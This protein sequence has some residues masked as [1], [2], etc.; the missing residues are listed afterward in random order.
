MRRIRIQK[1]KPRSRHEVEILPLDARDP[2]VVRAKALMRAREAVQDVRACSHSCHTRT[3]STPLA[4]ERRDGMHHVEVVSQDGSHST[5][6][7][8]PPRS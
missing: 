8:L 6:R 2:D 5:S 3:A 4:R 1:P 7:P